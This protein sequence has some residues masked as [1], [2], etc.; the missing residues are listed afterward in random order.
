MQQQVAIQFQISSSMEMDDG[1][2]DDEIEGIQHET[3]RVK[4]E[5]SMLGAEL[6]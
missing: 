2:N 4:G 6:I 5:F 3:P 1:W